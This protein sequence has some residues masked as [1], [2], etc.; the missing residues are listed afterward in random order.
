MSQL[1]LSVNLQAFGIES[2]SDQEIRDQLVLWRG[3]WDSKNCGSG[4][5]EASDGCPL[6][7]DPFSEA[8]YFHQVLPF[9]VVDDDDDQN[10]T[11]LAP[12]RRSTF[13]LILEL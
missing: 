11:S 10:V 7:Q 13:L 5:A 2:N 9:Y 3:S 1:P 4:R 12:R 8:G 6:K